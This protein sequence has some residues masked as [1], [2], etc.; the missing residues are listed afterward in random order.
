M[1]KLLLAV[2]ILGLA[3]AA[4]AEAVVCP[5]GSVPVI[6]DGVLYCVEIPRL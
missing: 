5:K 1:K 3:Y 6:I 2:A 4:T